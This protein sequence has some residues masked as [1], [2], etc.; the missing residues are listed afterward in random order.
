MRIALIVP[1]VLVGLVLLVTLIGW[2][3]PVKHRVTREAVLTVPAETLFALIA[4]P[5]DFPKWRTG[6][7]SVEILPSVGGLPSWVEHSS[8]GN[9]T[10]AVTR[11][12]PGVELVTTIADKRLPFGGSW[13]YEL[14]P[15][16]ALTTLRITEDGEVYNPIFRFLS[17]FVFGHAAT[18]E[19]YLKDVQRRAG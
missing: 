4:T 17:R 11:S 12:V 1:A 3:L 13:T 8:D 5:L 7:K 15:A 6:V 16:G 19:R 2:T 18:I 9:I 14:I 10:F